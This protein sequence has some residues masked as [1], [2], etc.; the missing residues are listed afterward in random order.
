MTAAASGVTLVRIRA[1]WLLPALI[2]GCVAVIVRWASAPYVVGVFHDDGIYALLARSLASGQG[3]H[4]AHLP[5][6][7]AAT[8]YPPLYPLML[9]S[10]WLLAPSFPRNVPTL[11]GLNALLI[12]LSAAGCWYFATARLGWPHKRGAVASLAV[13]VATPTLALAGALLSEP[14]F[15]AL[16][17]PAL[18]ASERVVDAPSR[19]RVLYAGALLGAL[20]LVRTH[21]V[22]LVAAVAIVLAA[23]HCWRQAFVVALVA[24]CVQAPWQLWSHW[25]TPR[26]AAPLEGAYGSYL[27]WFASGLRTGGPSFVLATMSTNAT[28]CWLLLR[29]RVTLGRSDAV[30]SVAGALLAVAALCGAWSLLRKA[31]VTFAF[32][33][34]YFGILLAWPYA[35]WR[36]LWAVWPLVMLLAV[37]GVRWCWTTAGHWRAVVALGAALPAFAVMRTELHAYAMRSWRL[38][39]QLAGAQIAPVVD[40]VQAHSSEHAVVLT[41]GEQVISLYTGRKAA[42]P[43]AFSAL[44]YLSPPSVADGSARLSAMLTAVPAQYVILLASDMMRAADALAT[45]HPGLRRIDALAVGVVYE[46]VP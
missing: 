17:W 13:T 37:E 14:L 42:P 26:V 16:L 44:E 33:V 20:M 41:E 22:A 25:A 9:A 15:L 18:L 27:G 38:P 35:P 32:I 1:A 31:P 21:G 19:S 30:V 5:G 34:C 24:E 28:E 36:F 39:A 46:I 6:T 10:V 11:L 29:D 43:I 12:G 23:R 45:G 3:F 40:W 7:P 2:I 8:H 4:Y